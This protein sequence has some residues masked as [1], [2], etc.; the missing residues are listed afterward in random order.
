MCD[1][2]MTVTKI[3]LSYCIRACSLH[4]VK[5]LRH[6]ERVPRRATKCV[7]GMKCKTYEQR[8][9]LLNITT[10][11]KRR[12]RADLIEVYRPTILSCKEDIDP[13]CFSVCFREIEFTWTSFEVVQET[14]SSQD[15]QVLLTENYQSVEFITEP[16]CGSSFCQQFHETFR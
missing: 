6:T 11:E 4:L 2:F 13:E 1:D 3:G 10:V 7:T 12:Q 5:T 8:L 14:A 9:Q 16:C 15:Q